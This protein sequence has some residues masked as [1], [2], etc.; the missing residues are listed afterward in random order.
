MMAAQPWWDIPPESPNRRMSHYLHIFRRHWQKM[1]AF[2]CTCTA[3]TLIVSLRVTPVYEST[4]VIDIDRHMPTGVVGQETSQPFVNDADQYLATQM[5]L[6]QSDAVLR[7]VDLKYNLRERERGLL[8]RWFGPEEEDPDAPL[9]LDR[10][11]VRRPPNTYLLEISYRSEHPQLAADVANAIAESYL[12][13]TYRTRYQAAKGMS[14]Y[15]ER[16]LEELR[17]RMERSGNALA[18]FE[19]ELSII[20]PEEQTSILSAHLLE[21]NSEY[22]R[23]QAVRVEKEAAYDSVQSGSLEAALAS[24]QGE[25][26][27]RTIRDYEKARQHF[28]DVRAFYGANHP[29]YKAAQLA[30][31]QLEQRIEELKKSIRGRVFVEFEE[32]RNR[33]RMLKDALA[34]VKAELDRVNARSFEYQALKREADSDKQLYEELLRKINEATVNA[35]FQGNSARIVDR[36]RPDDEPVFPKV[37]LNTLLAFLL[38]TGIACSIAITADYLDNTVRDPDQVMQTLRTQVLG[39][40]PMVRSWRGK[41]SVPVN[42]HAPG[43]RKRLVQK[44]QDSSVS[45]YNE[46]IR[47]LRNSI[48]L[49]DLDSTGRSLLITSASPGEGKSTTAVYLALAHASLKHKTLLIDG[50]LRRPSVH[51]R[52]HLASAKGLSTVLLYGGDWREAVL[53]PAGQPYLHVLP[54]GPSSRQAADL[55]GPSLGELLAEASAEYDLIILD[56]PPLLGFAEPMQMATAVDGVIIVTRAGVTN[57]RAVNSAVQTLSRIRANLLGIVLNEVH[58]QISDEYYYYSYYRKYYSESGNDRPSGDNGNG[59]EWREGS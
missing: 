8:S 18:Q 54:A 55:V 28:A 48:L 14:R 15:M 58:R 20:N 7:P 40:L 51:K 4:A 2:V 39:T 25:S 46:A 49:S 23:A 50:D 44:S 35:S 52:F 32:A 24:S 26:L 16:Q 36:A 37:P 42:G 27:A 9:E 30:V 21:L 5:R 11:S 3:L 29:E 33:E 57:R 53:R 56:A 47:S 22:A 41:F 6:I 43:R 12:E 31:G 38:A 10:V 17:A 34:K 1:C 19:K 45:S 59:E 13:H